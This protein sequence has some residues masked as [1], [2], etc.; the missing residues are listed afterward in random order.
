M[1]IFRETLA[2][3]LA[4]KRAELMAIAATTANTKKT[5]QETVANDDDSTTVSTPIERLDFSTSKTLKAME[6]FELERKKRSKKQS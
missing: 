5:K 1:E 4:K 3:T 2:A 6:A